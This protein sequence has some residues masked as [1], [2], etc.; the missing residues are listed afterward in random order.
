MVHRGLA[1]ISGAM[2]FCFLM[3][4]GVDTPFFFLHFYQSMIY[5]AILLMLFYLEDRWAYMLGMLAPV[6]WMILVL[7]NGQLLGALRQP[8]DYFAQGL[9]PT[10]VGIVLLLTALVSV[11]MFAGCLRHWRR[12]FAG[13]Q[14]LEHVLDQSADCVGLL[15]DSRRLVHPSVS[16]GLSRMLQATG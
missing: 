7:V 15:R 13:L 14:G 11:I 10:G 12:E 6:A 1:T 5:L 3:L 2:M 4:A 8:I 9:R 16:L